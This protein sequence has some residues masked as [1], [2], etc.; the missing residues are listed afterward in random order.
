[1]KGAP[2]AAVSAAFRATENLAQQAYSEENFDAAKRY[3][4]AIE[5]PVRQ[6]QGEQILKRLRELKAEQAELA[7]EFESVKTARERVKAGP[8][9]AEANLSVGRYLCFV[10]GDW[11]RGLPMLAKGSHAALKALAGKDLTTPRP[12][13]GQLA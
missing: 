10:Q 11:D 6:I 7:R 3:L 8:N 13:T 4:D 9:D 5:G 12:R 1:T 2:D